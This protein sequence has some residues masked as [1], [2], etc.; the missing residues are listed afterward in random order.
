MI[1]EA[2]NRDIPDCE[3]AFYPVSGSYIRVYN[4]I[5]DISLRKYDAYDSEDTSC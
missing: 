3:P 4:D 2:A 5:G 1:F